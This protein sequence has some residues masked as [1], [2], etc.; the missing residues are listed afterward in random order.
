M[1]QPKEYTND[2]T[3]DDDKLG[4]LIDVVF[5]DCVATRGISSISIAHSKSASN[6]VA[7]CGLSTTSARQETA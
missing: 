6:P 2:G 1:P 3:D 4:I 5:L 7:S